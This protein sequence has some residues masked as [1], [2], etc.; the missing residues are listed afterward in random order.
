MR[1]RCIA[2]VCVIGAV[3]SLVPFPA[4]GQ[5]V[6]GRPAPCPRR[7]HLFDKGTPGKSLVVFLDLLHVSHETTSSIRVS[8]TQRRNSWMRINR[9]SERD[10]DFSRRTFIKGVI[11]TSRMRSLVSAA[12]ECPP[13]K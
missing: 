12:I 5:P 4:A 9:L 1:S 11:A 6:R 13:K 8:N 10:Q 3:A 7:N 2:T